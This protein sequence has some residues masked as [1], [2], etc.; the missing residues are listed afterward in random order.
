MTRAYKHGDSSE[1]KFVAF[2]T[3]KHEAET[4]QIEKSAVVTSESSAT[5]S[6]YDSAATTYTNI[7]IHAIED[8]IALLIKNATYSVRS[9]FNQSAKCCR[10]KQHV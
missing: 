3:V 6:A 8:L 9:V 7:P 2:F 5:E 4:L 10:L 1:G